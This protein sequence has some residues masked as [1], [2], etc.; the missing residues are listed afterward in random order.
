MMGF[1]GGTLGET[2]QHENHPGSSRLLGTSS[3]HFASL[4]DSRGVVCLKYILGPVV[5]NV[6]SCMGR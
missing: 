3:A 5:A 2:V 4:R 6:S 1:R